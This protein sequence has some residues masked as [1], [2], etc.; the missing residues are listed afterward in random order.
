MRDVRGLQNELLD[1]RKLRQDSEANFAKVTTLLLP[2]G[3]SPEDAAKEKEAE[4]ERQQK[5]QLRR[6]VIYAELANLGM[7]RGRKR[8]KLLAELKV[9]EKGK[10]EEPQNET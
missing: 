5:N 1:E 3:Q 9:M 8:K 7:F 2:S 10:K 6:M 4:R